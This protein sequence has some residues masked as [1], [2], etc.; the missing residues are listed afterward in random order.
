MGDSPL[1]VSNLIGGDY[2]V[3]ETVVGSNNI[4]TRNYRIVEMVTVSG[5]L[6]R[7]NGVCVCVCVCVCMCVCVCVC[8]Y[9][10][11]CVCVLY[12]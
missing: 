8:V 2:T 11:V 5:G 6:L 3:E 12:S 4:S 1:V 9:V 7:S 10:C